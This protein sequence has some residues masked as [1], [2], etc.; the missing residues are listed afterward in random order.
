MKK[1]ILMLAIAT[2]G[3]TFYACSD[4]NSG[5]DGSYAYKVR[6]TDAPGPFSEVNVDIQ[7]VVVTGSN[8]EAVT[9]NTEAGIY[10]LLD[11]TNGADTLIATSTLTDSRVEQIRLILGPNNTVVLDGVT[12]PL[13]TPSAEQSGLKLQIHQDLL[14]D[15][16]NSIILD[17]DA[18]A[19]IIQTGN[20]TYKLKPVLRPVIAAI[21]GSIKGSVSP[22]GTL[23]MITVTSAD[24]LLVYTS[25]ADAEGNFQVSGLPAGTY[26]VTITPVLP[27]L[28]VVQ[29]DV[30][31]T[32]GASTDIGVIAF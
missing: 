11:F 5:S 16:D 21:S 1:I 27:L 22:A 7:S 14:A 20:G 13:S 28:P 23:A 8:G 4:D 2:I 15:I 18:N 31:V 26:T 12:Y 19:S 17:F 29:T 25:N 24:T 10:N 6:L 3:I 30:A 9:L 32:V